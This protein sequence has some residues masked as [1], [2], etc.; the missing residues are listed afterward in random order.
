MVKIRA[1]H[2]KEDLSPVWYF[3]MHFPVNNFYVQTTLSHD[4]FGS[5]PILLQFQTWYGRGWISLRY[6]GTFFC[7]RFIDIC[8]IYILGVISYDDD[9]WFEF[10]LP[11]RFRISSV[12]SSLSCSLISLYIWAV[13]WNITHASLVSICLS[14]L[15][16]ILETFTNPV[17]FLFLCLSWPSSVPLT[18]LI[19]DKVYLDDDLGV[20]SL[21]DCCAFISFMKNCSSAPNV[22]TS[23]GNPWAPYIYSDPTINSSSS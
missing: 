9:V 3:Q 1:V 18:C 17:L 10:R 15:L 11:R 2:Q 8:L 21:V 6:L 4:P 7:S 14:L 23:M 5:K 13:L 12:A 20:I 16:I 22:L 19:T